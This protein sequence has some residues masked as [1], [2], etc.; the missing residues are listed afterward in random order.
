MAVDLSAEAWE[1]L[2]WFAEV[3][4]E[5]VAF[6]NDRQYAALTE[7]IA[8]GYM[9]LEAKLTMSGSALYYRTLS[10]RGESS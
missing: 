6:L 2:V 10:N 3:D 5:D 9:A 1:L 4:R 8:A 7:L